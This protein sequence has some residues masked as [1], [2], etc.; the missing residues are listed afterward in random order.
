VEAYPYVVF[1][2]SAAFAA[3][4][5]YGLARRY[6]WIAAL[7]LPSLSLIAMIGMIWQATGAEAE[8][9]AGLLGPIVI[10]AAPIVAGVLIG[11]GIGV[12]RRR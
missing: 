2:A 7:L 12:W 5:C 1:A 11:T 3:V 10:F 8:D 6:G 4:I 9:L